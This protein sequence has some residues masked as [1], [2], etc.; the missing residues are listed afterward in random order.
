MSLSHSTD[1]GETIVILVLENFKQGSKYLLKVLELNY[2][3]F[4]K[5]CDIK[6]LKSSASAKIKIKFDYDLSSF[7]VSSFWNYNSGS[8]FIILED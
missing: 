6:T 2:S 7:V 4:I 8:L 5:G 1:E 3:D